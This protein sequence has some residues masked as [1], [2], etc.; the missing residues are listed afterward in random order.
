MYLF[1]KIGS[2]AFIAPAQYITSR[3]IVKFTLKCRKEPF[4]VQ[5]EANKDRSLARRIQSLQRFLL[6]K[7]HHEA[8]KRHP[9]T[10]QNLPEPSGRSQGANSAEGPASGKVRCKRFVSILP[11]LLQLSWH[12]CIKSIHVHWFRLLLHP[13]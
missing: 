7:L 5:V 6:D 8:A 3:A 1:V 10:F 9:R 4:S 2:P 12:L 11:S 13:S